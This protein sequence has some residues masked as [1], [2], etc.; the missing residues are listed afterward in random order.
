VALPD[1]I[2][3]RGGQHRQPGQGAK[4]PGDKEALPVP[5]MG[6]QPGNA[7]QNQKTRRVGAVEAPDHKGQ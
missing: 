2:S 1:G 7:L 4:R 6:Q 3:G 5:E